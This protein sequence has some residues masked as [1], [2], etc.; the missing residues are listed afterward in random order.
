[1][2]LS[3][4][5]ILFFL[6]FMIKTFRFPTTVS[7]SFTPL[8]CK[9]FSTATKPTHDTLSKIKTPVHGSFHWNTERALSVL[10]VPLL[11]TA[12]MYGAIPAVDIALGIVLPL[13]CHF[14]FECCI[15]DYQGKIADFLRMQSSTVYTIL[16]WML[17]VATGLALYGCYRINSTDVGIT[18]VFKRLWTGKI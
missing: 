16:I 5:S 9:S 2:V 14:G 13:H 17:R 10:T 3:L 15:T 1:M 11:G 18:T 4:D 7:K 12:A 8:F 6:F